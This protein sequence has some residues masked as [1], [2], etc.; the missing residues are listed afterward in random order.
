MDALSCV[1][2]RE[3]R[4]QERL[5]R[6]GRLD[7][8]SAAL[9]PAG[10]QGPQPAHVAVD[11]GSGHVVA[12]LGRP[13][14]QVKTVPQGHALLRGMSAATDGVRRLLFELTY[15]RCDEHVQPQCRVLSAY[16]QGVEP[17]DPNRQVR[18]P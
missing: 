11:V 17:V 16:E 3:R 13:Q 7:G 10:P 1:V 9:G 18:C 2:I 6:L 15:D 5:R 12:T 8:S 14:Y 4:K